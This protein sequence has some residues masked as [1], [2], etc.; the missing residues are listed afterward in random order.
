MLASARQRPVSISSLFQS[1]AELSRHNRL[2]STRIPLT[3][4]FGGG[5][6]LY[7]D[8]EWLPECDD[9]VRLVDV[10]CKQEPVAAF[11]SLQQLSNTRMDFVRTIRLDKTLQRYMANHDLASVTQTLR[12]AVIGSSTLSHLHAGIRVGGLRR[13]LLVEVYEGGY[14]LYRQEL[15]DP[16][17]GL[18][19]FKPD[20]V[21]LALDAT[22]LT[23][24]EGVS[25][26][27][28]LAM[29]K[30][31]WSAAQDS[32]GCTVIQQM[33]L[34][35][36]PPLLGNQE[37]LYSASPAAIISNVNA[38]L[39]QEA[40]RANVFLL[41]LDAMA[42][43]DGIA[44]WFDPALWHRAKQEV[45]PRVSNVYGDQVA[46][47]L[48]ALRGKSSKCLVLDLDNTLW[49][50][51][52]GEDGPNGIVIGPG[53][54]NG[55]AYS[56]FQLYVK[57]LSGRGVILAVCSKNDEAV[58]LR[59]FEERPEMILQHSDIAC[60]MANWEDKATNLRHVARRLNIGLNSLV[61][62]DDNPFERDLIR[63][64]LPMVAVPEMPKDPSEY[65]R[66]LA[67]AGYFEGIS[68]TREDRE[69]IR[70]Y[71]ANEA[72]EELRRKTT[73]MQGF[74]RA[75]RMKLV[76][77]TFDVRDIK[78]VVQLLNK[79][80]QFNLTGRRYTESEIQELMT[81][82]DVLTLQLRL[83]DV[84]GNSGLIALVIGGQTN[85]VLSLDTWLM[86][87]RVLGRNVEHA[88][89]EVLTHQ[90][91][92]MGCMRLLGEYRPTASN[93]M[94]QSHYQ[95]LGFNLEETKS[96]GTTRWSFPLD[97]TFSS[98]EAIEILTEEAYGTPGD[99]HS[100]D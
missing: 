47:I 91:R 98:T 8:L 7:Q 25:A 75:L 82:K 57:Q 73:D 68:V 28:I 69:R 77:S 2:P 100:A 93:A 58:A 74:L 72:R 88:T 78:R 54:E 81:R 56:A 16:D 79:T 53:S 37:H 33:L 6:S 67:A 17:S 21:L 38:S 95:K 48:A 4:W 96:D 39:R 12:L 51:V 44:T 49:G 20:V 70:E 15:M 46:R 50:G 11:S 23:A 41:G 92:S 14:G 45:H 1:T 63:R 43:E 18:H 62:V 42:A 60:F 90:A 59:A 61:F 36:L 64:E 3:Y 13:G 31:C 35:T 87:C 10:A 99:L 89:F 80:N 34:P 26:N 24:M 97:R 9:W 27:S 71:R 5:L 76:W 29:L 66:C 52:V 40:P 55:E 83:I 30:S 22:H 94:V 86:S 84:Y 65:V 85:G 32:L 19:N